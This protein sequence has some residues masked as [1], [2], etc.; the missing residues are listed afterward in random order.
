MIIDLN[1]SLDG[2]MAQ[3][4]FFYRVMVFAEQPTNAFDSNLYYHNIIKLSIVNPQLTSKLFNIS[5][6]VDFAAIEFSLFLN[7]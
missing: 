5:T 2:G 7:I 6:N 3:F 1:L 4:S